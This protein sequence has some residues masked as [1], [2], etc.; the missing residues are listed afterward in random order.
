MPTLNPVAVEN[1]QIG[2]VTRIDDDSVPRG[3][4]SDSLNWMTQGDKIELRGG[5]ALMGDEE[6]GVGRVTG[7]KKGDRFDEQEVL[8]VTHGRK[9]KYFNDVTEKWVETDTVDALPEASDGEDI[10]IDTYNSQAGAFFYLSSPRSSIFKVPMANPGSIVDQNSTSHR[11]KIKI[12][13]GS[14]FLWDRQDSEGGFDQNGLY[15]SQIDKDELSDYPETLAEVIGAGDGSI[16]TFAGT[17]SD[18]T[19]VKTCMYLRVTDGVESFTDTRNGTLVG[20]QGGTG[21]INYATGAFSV[22]FNTAPV[23]TQNITADYFIEDSTNGGIV[24][25]SKGVPR[26]AGEGFTLRQ[27]EGGARFQNMGTISDDEYCLHVKKTWKVTLSADD[28]T[29]T[30]LAHRQRTGIPYFRA[31]EEIERGILYVDVISGEDAFV[32]IMEQSEFS[33]KTQSPSISDRIDFNEYAFDKAVLKEWGVYDVLL[34]RLKTSTVNNRAFFFNTVWGSWDIT[35]YRGSVLQEYNGSLV[36]GDSGSNNVFTLF[37][38]FTD[39][40]ANIENR[41]VSGDDNL[42]IGGVKQINRFLIEGEIAKDQELE[43]WISLDGKDFVLYK[44]ITGRGPYVDLAEDVSVGGPTVGSTQVGG[45]TQATVVHNYTHEFK[46]NTGKFEKLRVK[47][48]APKVGYVSV[49]R[50]EFKDIRYKGRSITPQY[51]EV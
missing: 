31:M 16:K 51:A 37:S 5:Y 4:A 46:I 49:S 27:D 33:E 8:I 1:F 36:S 42:D 45:R 34:C 41:W 29:A 12:K 19:G 38:G 25:F 47:F 10:S 18:V 40:E 2:V 39:E 14:M 17:L 35:D 43:V 32:R 11:G 7:L 24:D 30:N 6:E 22:T 9:V 50:Y 28:E 3:G 15:R 44:T 20:N 21:S 26:I 13:K 48:V 23:N